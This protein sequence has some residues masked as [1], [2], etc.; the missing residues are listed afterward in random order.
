MNKKPLSTV[1]K[2]IREDNGLTQEEF[3]EK[4]DVTP[5][6]VLRWENNTIQFPRQD[7]VKKINELFEINLNDV[8][9]KKKKRIHSISAQTSGRKNISPWGIGIP[10]VVISDIVRGSSDKSGSSNTVVP[11]EDTTQ[12]MLSKIFGVPLKVINREI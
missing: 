7:I 1:I 5:L 2:K 10:N 12:E 8:V 4:L 11:E 6:T 3:A 9:Q